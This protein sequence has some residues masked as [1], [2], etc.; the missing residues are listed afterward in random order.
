MKTI[1]K[2]EYHS[3]YAKKYYLLHKNEYLKRTKNITLT[4]NKRYKNIKNNIDRKIILSYQKLQN[5]ID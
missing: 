2:K 5:N 1:N 4:I 3:Q